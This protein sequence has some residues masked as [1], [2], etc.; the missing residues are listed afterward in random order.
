MKTENDAYLTLAAL[1]A[2]GE[3]CQYEMLEK[4]R[5]WEVD[6]TVKARVMQKLVA[7]RYIDDERFAGENI[8]HILLGFRPHH[9]QHISAYAECASLVC[10][11]VDDKV[12]YPVILGKIKRFLESI[13]SGRKKIIENNLV[14][15]IA[16]DIKN[17]PEKYNQTTGLPYVNLEN[18]DESINLIRHSKI[19]YEFRTT[20]VDELHTEYDIMKIAKWI[21]G[22]QQYFLQ[23][24]E[25]KTT[26]PCQTFHTP[27]ENKLLSLKNIAQMYIQKVE[28]RG[29][30]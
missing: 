20:I 15:Y 25:N 13:D 10:G 27:S 26:V 18:I 21:A 24:F 8:S 16:M 30:R 11:N 3:H 4:M 12:L 29:I 1:C 7:G 19:K 28:I 14:D 6:E 17:S 9:L 23:P 2:Q 22:S 5:R